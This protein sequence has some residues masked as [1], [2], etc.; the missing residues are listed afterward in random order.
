MKNLMKGT[1]PPPVPYEEPVPDAPVGDPPA[2]PGLRTALAFVLV[3]FVSLAS[4]A[5][6][7]S[8]TSTT[9]ID[10]TATN[11]QP[12]G[13]GGEPG[14]PASPVPSGAIDHVKVT[15]FG[16]SCGEEGRNISV[17]CQKFL[18][19]TPFFA[20]G[21]LVPPAIHG[22]RPDFFGVIEGAQFV[23]V[24]TP[25]EEFNRDVKGLFAG[26]VKFECIV[27]GVSSG[28][29]EFVVVDNPQGSALLPEDFVPQGIR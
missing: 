23:Q 9:I 1:E 5:C 10:N 17:G 25:D 11:N 8:P 21:T 16:Q 26:I 7:D 22:P 18:T 6:F 14:A 24:T 2:E 13:S 12:N 4:F 27:K 20:D 3:L 28:P 15:Q 29:S 19:C